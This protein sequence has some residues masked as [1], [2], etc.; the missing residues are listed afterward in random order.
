M[1]S[2]WEIYW[3]FLIWEL[4]GVSY[5][6]TADENMIAFCESLGIPSKLSFN[7]IVEK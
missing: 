1:Q 6:Y 2:E 7:F 5:K 4:S 3:R